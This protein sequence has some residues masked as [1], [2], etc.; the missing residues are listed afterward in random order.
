MFEAASKP[1]SQAYKQGNSQ[2]QE[3][4]DQKQ[5]NKTHMAK[6]ENELTAKIRE[7]ETLDKKVI[8][9]TNELNQL[10][11]KIE[12][13]F[14]QQ[15]IFEI[16]NQEI[17]KKNSS[18]A[19]TDNMKVVKYHQ[20]VTALFDDIIDIQRGQMLDDIRGNAAMLSGLSQIKQIVEAVCVKLIVADPNE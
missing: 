8:I 7:M 10:N 6:L 5:R 11:N 1:A 16:Q 2:V 13:E 17:N 15:K 4:I 12:H 18:S 20:Q 14:K 19:K 9:S 3:L